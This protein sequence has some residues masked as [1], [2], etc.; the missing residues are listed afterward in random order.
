[1]LVRTARRLEDE[2]IS[3]AVRKNRALGE[4]QGEQPAAMERRFLLTKF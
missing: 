2:T 4:H 1:V 3:A